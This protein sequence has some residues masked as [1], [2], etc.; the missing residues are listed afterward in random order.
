MDD[1]ATAAAAPGYADGDRHCDAGDDP[2]A[3][4]D[5]TAD[6]AA[7]DAGDGLSAHVAH[8]G[9][10]RDRGLGGSARDDLE[11]AGLVGAERGDPAAFEGTLVVRDEAAVRVGVD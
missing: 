3:G 1:L 8:A 9:A 11:C 6:H 10:H 7:E 2:G 5:D 4:Q